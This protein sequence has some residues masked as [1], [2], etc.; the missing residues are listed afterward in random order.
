M[1]ISAR[2]PCSAAWLATQGMDDVPVV[3]DAAVLAG[4]MRPPAAQRHQRRRAEEAFEPVVVEAHAKAFAIRVAR[5][6][7]RGSGQMA[8]ARGG[9]SLV[10]SIP[11][12]T[13]PPC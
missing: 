2:S 7:M 5:S 1:R 10:W 11:T 6:W 3:D 9:S 13:V 12:M 8:A 4:G